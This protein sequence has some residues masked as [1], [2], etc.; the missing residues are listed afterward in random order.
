MLMKGG[1]V[2]TRAIVYKKESLRMGAEMREANDRSTTKNSAR[3]LNKILP[4]N[5]HVVG[6]LVK[7]ARNRDHTSVCVLLTGVYKGIEKSKSTGA[8]IQRHEEEKVN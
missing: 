4:L 3:N 6:S 2:K 8:Q 1:G 7:N 5:R